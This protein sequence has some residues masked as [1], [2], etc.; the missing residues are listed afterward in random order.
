MMLIQ[1]DCAMLQ[2]INVLLRVHQKMD[3]LPIQKH[4][5]VDLVFVILPKV[6]IVLRRQIN[7]VHFHFVLRMMDLVRMPTTVVVAQLHVWHL[8]A[9]IAML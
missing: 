5:H 7:V 3:Y 1:E 6:C 4:V 8:L 2:L 9:C